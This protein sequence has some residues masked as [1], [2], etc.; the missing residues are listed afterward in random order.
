MMETQE[1]PVDSREECA[2]LLAERE[3]K[4]I[5]TGGPKY[6]TID[7]CQAYRVGCSNKTKYSKTSQQKR[8]I[9]TSESTK[10][11]EKQF[12]KSPG[13]FLDEMIKTIAKPIYNWI[14]LH[15]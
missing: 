12:N 6:L 9:F 2:Y 10:N 5:E 13:K 8:S 4:T 7:P 11:N 3:D 15:V 1:L 14:M